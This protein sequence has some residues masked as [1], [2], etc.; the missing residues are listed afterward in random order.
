MTK[1]IFAALA[2][3]QAA[4]G[5]LSKDGDGTR[6]AYVSVDSA[7]AASKKAL[8][9]N[10]LLFVQT[11][12][13][14]IE[15]TR[16]NPE[17]D[18]KG[19]AKPAPTLISRDVLLVHVETG[20][21][22]SLGQTWPVNM[23]GNRDRSIDHNV[24]AADSFG[25]TYL[26]RGLLLFPRG[27]EHDTSDKPKTVDEYGA[28]RYDT[29]PAD[30]KPTI[31]KTVA[32][33]EATVVNYAAMLLTGKLSGECCK[34]IK[35]GQKPFKANAASLEACNWTGKPNAEDLAVVGEDG[36]IPDPMKKHLW[37][38]CVDRVGADKIKKVWG[39]LVPA[40]SNPTG[41]QATVI[42]IICSK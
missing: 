21:T 26:L 2:K 1:K 38:A 36:I 7:V 27:D 10:G 24:A 29:K 11:G 13:R 19:N 41:F 5:A 15:M 20:E 25:L 6:G 23:Y 18:A 39:A 14:V 16:S 33:S 35:S 28:Q 42:A 37:K 8:V 4:I 22:L 34:M 17:E 9:D 3:A 31:E 32:E 12:L 30:N 40:K